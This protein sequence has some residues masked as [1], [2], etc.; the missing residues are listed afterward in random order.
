[1]DFFNGK[2]AEMFG[3]CVYGVGCAEVEVDCLTGDHKVLR[4]DIVM[5]VGDSLNPAV[6]IG[7]IE[8]A[9]VQ[10]KG[11]FYNCNGKNA[12]FRVMACL[13]WKN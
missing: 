5:D 2:G 6:D 10:V 11:T 12:L 1:M 3:Y 7:Q 13:P 8:G 9:Y 4:S